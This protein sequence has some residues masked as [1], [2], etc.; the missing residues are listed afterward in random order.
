MNSNMICGYTVSYLVNHMN[1][2]M[3]DVYVAIIEND[4]KIYFYPRNDTKYLNTLVPSSS[5]IFKLKNNFTWIETYNCKNQ[6]V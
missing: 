1:N 3:V 6:A 4:P 5:A 2:H